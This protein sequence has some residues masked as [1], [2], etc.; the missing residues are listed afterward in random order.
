VGKT[1]EVLGPRTARSLS[2]G[3]GKV[4]V[5]AMKFTLDLTPEEFDKFQLEMLM[6]SDAGVAES[7]YQ[8]DGMRALRK[9]IEEQIKTPFG[10]TPEI[11]YVYVQHKGTDLC[12]DFHCVCGESFHIDDDFVYGVQCPYCE[13]KLEVGCYLGMREI[14]SDEK[15]E[16]NIIQ[17]KK[18]IEL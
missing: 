2:L 3:A 10:I 6:A 17:G 14:G 13:R 1:T 9:K 5:E 7:G 11:P 18:D 8:S 16:L 4:R 15:F 12:G